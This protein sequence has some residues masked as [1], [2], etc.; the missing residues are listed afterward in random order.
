MVQ[1]KIIMMSFEECS[2]CSEIFSS[3]DLLL[4]LQKCRKSSEP[5]S[6]SHYESINPLA[7][8][9]KKLTYFSQNDHWSCGYRNLLM[10]LSSFGIYHEIPILQSIIEKAWT[11]GW[12]P[13]GFQE[14]G[15][16][17]K[18]KIG[19]PEIYTCLTFLGIN[20]IVYDFTRKIDG[21]HLHLQDVV[22][23]HFDSEQAY[24]LYLQHD[25][26]SRT[27]VGTYK[28]SIL[29]FDPANSKLFH[30]LYRSND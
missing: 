12:D 10:I 24:P 25:G 19:T 5:P 14:L 11:E 1:S 23:K 4:H 27:A 18:T 28:S 13:K 30:I 2:K 16:L 9:C 3:S 26:H 15:K 8:K 6:P 21:G 20:V 29:L 7:K 17:S 22:E